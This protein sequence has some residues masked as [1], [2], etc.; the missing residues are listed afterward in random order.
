MKHGN[1]LALA[2]CPHCGTAR[3]LLLLKWYEL[4]E[5]CNGNSKSYW[6]VYRCNTCGGMVAAVSPDGALSPVSRYWPASVEVAEDIPPRARDYLTQAADSLQ[7]PSGAVMLCASSIDAMLKASGYKDGSLY[8]RIDK[9]AEDHVITA[10]MAAWAHE[11]R[12]D[13]ND[14]RHADEEAPLPTL[15]DAKRA[16]EFAQALAQLMFVLPARVARGRKEATP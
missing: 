11:V 3:P 6:A 13:A 14:Q 7:S 2:R 12:L 10:D 4:S 5:D 16:F 1:Q 8:A 15:A 9:S